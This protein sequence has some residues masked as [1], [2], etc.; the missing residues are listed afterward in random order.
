MITT[1]ISS[2]LSDGFMAACCACACAFQS[3]YGQSLKTLILQF[4]RNYP[5]EYILLGRDG[6]DAGARAAGAMDEDS[7]MEALLRKTRS[8]SL[9][10]E[11]FDMFCK[12]TMSGSGN[13]L[14][15]ASIPRLSDFR[16]EVVADRDSIKKLF[17]GADKV[18]DLVY[19]IADGKD[20]T[21]CNALC[22]ASDMAIV[23]VPQGAFQ[24]SY[25][26][27]DKKT[28]LI[29]SFDERSR[30]NVNRMKK[31]YQVPDS[32]IFTLPYNVGF[33]DAGRDEMLIRFLYTNQAGKKEDNEN[34]A[35]MEDLSRAAAATAGNTIKKVTFGQHSF[36]RKHVQERLE[37][38]DKVELLA[39]NIVINKQ[40]KFL[41][42]EMVSVSAGGT[43]GAK[44]AKTHANEKKE[45]RA[46]LR[47]EKKAKKQDEALKKKELA[48]GL[49]EQDKSKKALKDKKKNTK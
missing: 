2:T 8:F 24:P 49:S 46:K 42:G 29:T 21:L 30:Y 31:I 14:D 18:Y 47:E 25:G 1:F 16:D 15:V 45:K 5:A 23:C 11:D 22:D 36:E 37:R 35:F 44:F 33:L 26:A 13:Q 7:G 10:E 48:Q 34:G 19:V 6:R 43:D 40:K 41:K 28:Y 9:H 4:S 17:Q 32:R 12:H 3:A 39:E 20:E 27:E 38:M